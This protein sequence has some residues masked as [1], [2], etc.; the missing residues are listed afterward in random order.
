[1]LEPGT[2]PLSWNNPKLVVNQDPPIYRKHQE[3]EV[4]LSRK[5]QEYP[6]TC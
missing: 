1:M 4:F 2:S 3:Q 5:I 6:T